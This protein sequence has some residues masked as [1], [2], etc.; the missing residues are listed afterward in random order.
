M[1]LGAV[2]VEFIDGM[3][4]PGAH[5][6]NLVEG[7]DCVVMCLAWTKHSTSSIVR[8]RARG[9]IC[10]MTVAG[11]RAFREAVVAGDPQDRPPVPT[12]VG[13]MPAHT[14]TLR[15]VGSAARSR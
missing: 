2:H 5:L 14:R 11:L 7:A 6:R 10:E 3:L 15:V 12:A 8:R 9:R 1:S 4:H 13:A